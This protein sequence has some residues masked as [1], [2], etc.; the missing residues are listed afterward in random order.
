MSEHSLPPPTVLHRWGGV[1]SAAQHESIPMASSQP[2]P[3]GQETEENATKKDPGAKERP[4]G[5]RPDGYDTL[6]SELDKN[7]R[8][9][10]IFRKDATLYDQNITIHEWNATLD[11]LLVF[12]ALFLGVVTSFV[13]QT[14]SMFVAHEDMDAHNSQTQTSSAPPLFWIM[15]GL[16]FLSLLISLVV[17]LFCILAKQWL[18][19][20]IR[21][22]SEPTPH[23]RLWA[24]RRWIYMHGLEQWRVGLMATDGLPLLLHLALLLFAIGLVLLLM[25]IK[26]SIAWLVGSVAVVVGTIYLAITLAP[27]FWVNAPTATPLLRQFGGLFIPQDPPEAIETTQGRLIVVDSDLAIPSPHAAPTRGHV[28]DLLT[29]PRSEVEKAYIAHYKKRM[30]YS[31]LVWLLTVSRSEDALT[32]A[33][34]AVSALPWDSEALV[35]VRQTGIGLAD[36]FQSM[37]SSKLRAVDVMRMIRS[38]LYLRPGDWGRYKLGLDIPNAMLD[39]LRDA[40]SPDAG[41]LFASMQK[42][43]DRLDL[44]AR[45]ASLWREKDSVSM[46]STLQLLLQSWRIEPR[47]VFHLMLALKP[48]RLG[49]MWDDFVTL[50]SNHY[51]RAPGSTKNVSGAAGAVPPPAPQTAKA[52]QVLET[53]LTLALVILAHVTTRFA[54]SSDEFILAAQLAMRIV[55]LLP[56]RAVATDRFQSLHWQT[57]LEHIGSHAGNIFRSLQSR[58]P[59]LGWCRTQGRLLYFI[60]ARWLLEPPSRHRVLL[61]Y[62]AG[63]VLETLLNAFDNPEFTDQV[64]PVNV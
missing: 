16:W 13:I 31:A 30:E 1:G 42:D 62:R 29:R 38:E 61:G 17:S 48:S 4:K 37:S 43:G 21:R 26:M 60:V 9:W 11:V 45:S 24:Q 63:Y 27:A 47:A 22:L 54:C 25:M 19:E 49:D 8:L 56:T 32:V 15:L 36:A 58:D 40:Q 52:D 12:A 33:F 23:V 39:L 10:H 3:A 59:V 64:C 5:K 7:A 50:G 20:Y 6:G 34:G 2:A 46:R 35:L 14:Y 28:L 53:N 18:H 44:I 55:R 41:V 57:P 51:L